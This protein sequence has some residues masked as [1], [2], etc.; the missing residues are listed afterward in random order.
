MSQQDLPAAHTRRAGPVTGGRDAAWLVIARRDGARVVLAGCLL[1][2][3]AVGLRT[4]IAPPR[5]NGPL[6]HDGLVLGGI[7][8]AALA[9]L[10]VALIVRHRRA[11]GSALAAAR[12]R[13]V[14]GYVVGAGLIAIPALS[15]LSLQEGPVRQRPA[16]A[17]PRPAPAGSHRAAQ[18]AAGG[19]SP[20]ETIIVA[21]AALAAAVLIALA[22]VSLWRYLRQRPWRSRRSYRM[23]AG[24]GDGEPE[25]RDAVE[26]G[27]GALAGVD[28]A[29]AAI[30]ACYL[31]MEQS[32]GR[33]GT[34]R[35]AADTPDELLARAARQ[36][37]VRGQAA[38]LLTGLFY[39]ARFSSHPMHQAD[40]DRAQ[41]ALASL[42]AGL[43]RTSAAGGAHAGAGTR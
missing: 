29:R 3:A 39:E 19:T 24:A 17:R 9:C 34:P 12:L 15:L 35:G 6:A 10:T 37:L 8:E 16:P 14:L 40:R 23:L 5:L 1:A 11:P 18:H 38:D 41:Q 21:I 28:D 36:G 20:V 7:L 2:L 31:A 13:K 4:A 42:A 33:A 32:L 30:I 25:L 26:A 43:D 27:Y 22:A